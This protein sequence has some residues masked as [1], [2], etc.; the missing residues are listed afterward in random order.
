[1]V[2][3]EIASIDVNL[4]LRPTRNYFGRLLIPLFWTPD[5]AIYWFGSFG[6]SLVL[7]LTGEKV[8]FTFLSKCNKR[9]L[10]GLCMHDFNTI[11]NF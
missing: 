3:F 2:F 7:H 1:M 6:S 10:V 4:Y 9:K 11:F 5:E 8:Q